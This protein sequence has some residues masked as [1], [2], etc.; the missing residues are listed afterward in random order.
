MKDWKEAV[1][2]YFQFSK[3]DRI[4][5]LIIMITTGLVFFLPSFVGKKTSQQQQTDTTWIAGIKQLEQKNAEPEKNYATNNEAD[6]SQQ[7]QYDRPTG[8]YA[9]TKGGLFYFDPNTL[10]PDGW[11]KLG[12]RD[13]TIHTI[14]NYLSKGGKFRKPEDVQRIY[15]LFPD[16]YQRIANYIRIENL[17]T[18]AMASN[19]STVET[20]PAKT[21]ASKAANYMVQDLNTADT[22][23][24][25]RLPGIGSKLASRIVTFRDKLGGF[26]SVEQVKET[27][28]LPDSVFQR[29][30]KH[31]NLIS[32]V[33]K[34]NIN[35]ATVDELK[36]H[37]YIKWA[38]ANP[39]VAYRNTHGPFE[40][41]TD[42]KKVMV[43]TEDIFNKV[44]PY[45]TLQ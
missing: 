44:Q 36:T 2:E 18:G 45:I 6:N 5:I 13:K 33:K 30:K 23:T 4:A 32:S 29:I 12:L 9:K 31:L 38:I 26:Y 10:S 11:K 7:Y 15:G 27:Y 39:L 42:L 37:P 35:T 16:E 22:T 3:R 21:T 40:K 20:S 43:V 1:A 17:A 8:H 28:G 34:I 24:L 41:A 14:Q 25:I 19:G